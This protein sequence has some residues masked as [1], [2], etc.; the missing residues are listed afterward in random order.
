MA[1]DE[2]LRGHFTTSSL[3]DGHPKGHFIMFY[4]PQEHPRGHVRCIFFLKW[5]HQGRRSTFG[6]L[7]PGQPETHL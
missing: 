7:E 3:L 4:P 5:E 1:L 6:L 2:H